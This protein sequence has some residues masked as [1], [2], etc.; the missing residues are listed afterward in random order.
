[1]ED[2]ISVHVVEGLEEL[3]H[4]PFDFLLI[5]LFCSVLDVFIHILNHEFEHHCNSLG[6][7]VT[8]VDEWILGLGY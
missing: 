7:F 4:V 5:E 3:E 2:S 1:M 8:G 6:W